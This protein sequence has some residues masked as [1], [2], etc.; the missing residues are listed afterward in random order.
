[1]RDGDLYLFWKGMADLPS[2]LS[3]AESA[4]QAEGP[5]VSQISGKQRD[6]MLNVVP[7]L[8]RRGTQSMSQR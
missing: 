7:I 5:P 6:V 1:M 8:E 4:L 2:L 3:A